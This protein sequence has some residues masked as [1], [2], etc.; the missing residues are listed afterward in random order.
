MQSQSKKRLRAITYIF[1]MKKT[2]F[3]ITELCASDTA[4][5][6]GID[7]TPPPEVVKC[8]QLLIS[9]VLDPLRESY[10]M[11]IS[12]NCGYRCAKLNAKVGGVPTSQHLK[13]EAVDIRN[14]PELQA[15]ILAMV[16]AQKITIDQLIVENPDSKG[17]GE[18]LHLSYS[19]TRRRDQI[20]TAI[21]G[22]FRRLKL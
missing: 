20:L 14:S 15:H 3:T 17:V 4:K 7:N 12:I 21:K 5:M 16:K 9:E 8:L 1:N 11:P 13:G 6:H 2:Y 19:R 18:W 22:V 10:G